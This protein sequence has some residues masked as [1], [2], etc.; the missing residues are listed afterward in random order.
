MGLEHHLPQMK[1]YYDKTVDIA[2]AI[3]QLDDI[4]IKPA[5]PDCNRMF[6]YFRR[7]NQRLIDTVLD[8]ASETQT[9]LFYSSKQSPI[10][11]YAMTEIWIGNAALD[12]ATDDIA[13]LFADL[14]RRSA[15]QK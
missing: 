1:A 11:A 10:P 6:V 4:E 7:D 9:L 12:L 2:V 5:I 3:S 8:I 14:M 13:A 15:N